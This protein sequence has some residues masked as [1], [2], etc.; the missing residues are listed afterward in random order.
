MKK[1]LGI[2]VLSLL[3]FSNVYAECKEGNCS[4][5]TGTMVWPNGDQY[6]GEW[7]DGK[8]HGVGTLTWSGGTKYTGDWKNGIQDGIGTLTWPNGDQYVGERKDSKASG[9]GTSIETILGGTVII[10]TIAI[11]SFL[12]LKNT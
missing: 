7:K 9:Q 2:I 3:C 12:K 6:V 8:I 11:H 10:L 1:L 5:G 4:N